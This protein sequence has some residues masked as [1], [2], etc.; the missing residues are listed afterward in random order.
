MPLQTFDTTHTLT[1][2]AHVMPSIRSSQVSESPGL[3]V[4]GSSS[5][6]ES[7]SLPELGERRGD[8][9]QRPLSVFEKAAMDDDKGEN[10]EK[11]R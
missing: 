10:E 3:D 6:V 8:L 7:S 9:A 5:I 2:L 11:E 1:Q 4:S